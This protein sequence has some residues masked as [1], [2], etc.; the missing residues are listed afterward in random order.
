M[1]GQLG[2]IKNNPLKSRIPCPENPDYIAIDLDPTVKDRKGGYLGNLLA[3][4]LAAKEY[5]DKHKLTAFAKT[6]GKTGMH[7]YIPCAGVTF[8]QA[9][10][11]AEHICRK[12]VDMVPEA[13]TFANSINSRQDKVYVDPS[14]NDYADTLASPYSIRPWHLPTVST[15]LEWKE[16][17]QK[18]NPSDFTIETILPRIKRK[19]DLFKGVLD[20][21]TAAANTKK[22][23]T[24]LTK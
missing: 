6:S 13:A 12:I 21:R 15:P 4:A 18:L 19:G 3:T 9:R 8:T 17:N 5:M 24:L 11:M 2:L 23:Q 14:Q 22:L 16:I 20:K 7:F 10:S 1:D